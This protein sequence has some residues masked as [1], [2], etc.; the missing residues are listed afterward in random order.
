MPA[1][2]HQFSPAVWD[3][4]MRRLS[5]PAT[6]V[7]LYIMTAPT[8][9]TEGLFAL[10]VG[11]I[12]HDTGLSEENVEK[13]LAELAEAGLVDYDHDAEVV[14]DRWALRYTPLRNGTTTDKTTGEVKV[15]PDNRIPAAVKLFEQVP[16]SP[17]KVEFYRLAR[18]HSPDLAY[19]LGERFPSLTLHAEEPPPEPPSKPL[20]SPLEGPRKGRVEKSRDEQR[21]AEPEKSGEGLLLCGVE[22]CKRSAAFRDSEDGALLCQEHRVAV[23]GELV[24]LEVAG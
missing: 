22:D 13:G 15:K 17:L 10:P 16:S 3:R 9:V 11:I 12:V 24:P 19:A 6:L 14:L 18:E 7:R 5:G 2:F 23:W 20:G 21:R 8:K 1:K 4:T